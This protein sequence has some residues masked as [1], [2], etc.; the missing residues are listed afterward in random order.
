MAST[1]FNLSDP[2]VD[3]S[4]YALVSQLPVSNVL[5]GGP[6]TVDTLPTPDAS[7]LDRYAR[8]TDLFGE[9]R[10]LVLCSQVGGVYFWQPVRATYAKSIAGNVDTTLTTLKSPS[11]VFMT[12]NLTANRTV[13]LS[14]T[15]AY[16]GATFEVAMQGTLGINTLTIAGLAL[17]ATVSMIL[18]GRKRFFYD[19]AWREF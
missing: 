3:L 11:V 6:Y 14:T 1:K 4:G 7:N 16:P 2:A 10:D 13:T 17:G 15:N 19:T 9:K 5:T 12:A 18:G 8:V